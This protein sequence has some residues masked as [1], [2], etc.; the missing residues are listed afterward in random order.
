MSTNSI[1]VKAAVA[2]A[3]LSP[4]GVRRLDDLVRDKFL[5]PELEKVKAL[6]Q[7][8]ALHDALGDE[9]GNVFV[10]LTTPK[11]RAILKA[12]GWPAAEAVSLSDDEMRVLL[13]D[14]FAGRKAPPT[15]APARKPPAKKAPSP[16]A[17][18]DV[19]ALYQKGGMP[20]LY[21][22]ISQLPAPKLK[23][24]IKEQKLVVD[25]K[26]GTK[27]DDLLRYV[28][29]AVKEELG[30]RGDWIGKLSQITDDD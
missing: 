1:A 21:G 16:S 23:T 8:R 12:V 10:K 18:P 4:D 24:L 26:M 19:R 27:K 20:L 14:L 7:A 6:D 28:Q 3:H 17:L 2:L 25:A 9:F 11:A 29:L 15:K 5:L 30:R 22:E 13:R